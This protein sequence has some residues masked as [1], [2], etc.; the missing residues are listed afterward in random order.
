MPDAEAMLDDLLQRHL[1]HY[2][3]PYPN[4]TSEQRALEDLNVH[5]AAVLDRMQPQG[6]EYGVELIG[7][8]VILGVHLY[9]DS[10][11]VGD[12]VRIIKMEDK[13]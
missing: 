5:R 9:S 2:T 4:R 10:H 3:G 11:A 13:S 7:G 6:E 1:S 8:R 12:K